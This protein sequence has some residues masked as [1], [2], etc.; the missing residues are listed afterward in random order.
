MNRFEQ[1]KTHHPQKYFGLLPIGAFLVL[2]ALFLHSL[3]SVSETTLAKQQE[4]LETALYRS[5]VQCYTLEGTYPPSLAYI[6]THYG[7]I[8]DKNL[9]F[10][11][12]RPIGS[13]IMPD[14]TIIRKTGEEADDAKYKP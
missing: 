3:S 1:N 8:Y 5:V 10:I 12:Y 14:I 2:F 4:S 13:N 7:L 9:F 11:D 6:E